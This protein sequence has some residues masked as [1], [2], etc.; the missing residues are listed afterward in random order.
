V[1]THR[2]GKAGLITVARDCVV[3]VGRKYAANH[4]I[5]IRR[6]DQLTIIETETAVIIGALIIDP[7]RRTQ[8]TRPST[9]RK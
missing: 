1:R 6:G 4:V 9:R 7:E 3:Y 2:V 5:T 8:T